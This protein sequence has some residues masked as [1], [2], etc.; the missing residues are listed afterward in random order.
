MLVA[1]DPS[2]PRVAYMQSLDGT[3]TQSATVSELEESVSYV[4]SISVETSEGPSPVMEQ[5]FM[6]DPSGKY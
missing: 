5:C 3:L 6:T 1:A 2:E 4:F